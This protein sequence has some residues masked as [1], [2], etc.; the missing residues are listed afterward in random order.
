MTLAAV[1]GL[2]M[3][4]FGAV[5]WPF[6]GPRLRGGDGRPRAAQ[7]WEDLMAQ[8]DTAYQALKELEFEYNLGNLSDADYSD[9]R[10]RYRAQAAGI[11]QKLDTEMNPR[12]EEPPA[13][14]SPQTPLLGC[15]S[16]GEGIEPEDTY[17]WRC[18]QRLDR[19][20]DD[21]GELLAADDRFCGGCGRS[22]EV[23]A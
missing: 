2:M 22:L 12:P 5:A 15:A 23:L 3:V 11:L 18:G 14:L 13:P 8:R 16:C 17:C 6:L 9:L 21:C 4:S 19:R 10:D 1:L 7:P 20:C